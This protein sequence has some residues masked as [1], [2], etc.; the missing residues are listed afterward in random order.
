MNFQEF[1]EKNPI[2]LHDP[3]FSESPMIEERAAEYGWNSCKREVI[4][5][6]KEYEGY[7]VHT[8]NVIKLLSKTF[9]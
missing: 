2:W 3:Y 5:M 7:D 8:E 6:L 9:S 1:W 4:K